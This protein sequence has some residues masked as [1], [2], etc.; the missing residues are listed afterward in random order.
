MSGLR[1]SHWRWRIREGFGPLV[2]RPGP[3][4]LAKS[5]LLADAHGEGSRGDSDADLE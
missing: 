3:A 1:D 5:Q 2:P 4:D